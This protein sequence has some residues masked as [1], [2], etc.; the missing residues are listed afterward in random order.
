MSKIDYIAPPI[1]KNFE[2][3][4]GLVHTQI[5][6]KNKTNVEHLNSISR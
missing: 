4:K 1:Y 3:K 6:I 5:A 2:V